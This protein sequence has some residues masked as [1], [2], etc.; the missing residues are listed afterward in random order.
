[1]AGAGTNRTLSNTPRVKRQ[2]TDRKTYHNLI[3]I[4]CFWHHLTLILGVIAPVTDWF[5]IFGAGSSSSTPVTFLMLDNRYQ[6]NSDGQ[7]HTGDSKSLLNAGD[8]FNST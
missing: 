8:N 7:Q 6:E 2:F 5:T 1:M 3:L 4:F